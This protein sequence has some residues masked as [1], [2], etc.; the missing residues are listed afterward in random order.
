M[1][2]FNKLGITS[3]TITLYKINEVALYSSEIISTNGN[4][5]HP[6]DMETSLTFKVYKN[7][8]D[9]TNN[10]T[11]IEWRKFSFDS[12]EI[13]E[14]E[15][16][17]RDYKNLKT[18]KIN[19]NDFDKKC[20]IQA[21]AYELVGNR[22]QCVASARITLIDV[23]ELYSNNTPPENPSEGALWVDTSGDTSIIYTWN[24]EF[25]EWRVV[26]RTNPAVRNLINNSNF[27]RLN[28]TGF[29]SEKEDFLLNLKTEY[30]FEKNWLNLKTY[31]PTL[32]EDMTAGV[33]QT[34]SYPIIH[35]SDYTFSLK[36]YRKNTDEYIG[37]NLF[38]KI[39]S[40]DKDEVATEICTLLKHISNDY[41]DQISYSFKSLDDTENIKV[42]IGV[43]P[44]KM[45]DFYITELSLYNTNR[46]YPWESSPE[47]L[48]QQLETK[49]N[50]DQESVFNALTKNGEMEGIYVSVDEDGKEHY[51]FNATHIKTGSL[52]GGL[53]NGIGLN[54]KDD[55][56]G[57]SI[58]HVYK[59]ED[60]THIDMVAQNLY[61]GTEPASTKQYAES[62]AAEAESNAAGY[63]NTTVA[64]NREESERI[65][66]G[67]IATSATNV[68]T[69][70]TEY[71]DTQIS[72]AISTN[73]G[74]TNGAIGTS[75]AA[76]KT[77]ISNTEKACKKYT[78]DEIDDLVKDIND[79][80]STVNSN[81]SKAKSDAVSDSKK[82]TDEEL[83]TH[84]TSMTEYIDKKVKSV[85]DVVVKKADSSTVSG[86]DARLATVESKVVPSVLVSTVTSSI[87]YK[88]AI[89]KMM[90][91]ESFNT[92]KK[93]LDEDLSEMNKD[94]SNRVL[95]TKV[96][97]AINNSS[98]SVKI[99][100]DKLDLSAVTGTIDTPTDGIYASTLFSKGGLILTPDKEKS[101]LTI[102]TIISNMDFNVNNLDIELDISSIA[103]TNYVK[104]STGNAQIYL[105]DHEIIK[106]LLHQMNSMQ[107]RIDELEKTLD[108]LKDASLEQ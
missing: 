58:F 47:D 4:I 103:G 99:S 97:E 73:E 81:I 38:I 82:Y 45:C 6:Y 52:D 80:F 29:V 18:I 104:K 3:A 79:A 69:E 28:A 108:S 14:D 63:T 101:D 49:L 53:I 39:I 74:F 88:T 7:S 75:E 68:I 71:V 85:N 41:K 83:N 11:H 15:V 23:N 9:I 96:V 93:D 37:E 34:T 5:F 60:G 46:I 91:T 16:W 78:D 25:K 33:C 76:L 30:M 22:E 61:I 87:E 66:N 21:D 92:F 94:I 8:M 44:M 19:K 107:K 106:L 84:T 55:V 89:S 43:E 102:D 56:T 40:L 32:Y 62:K 98:E 12:S 100:K 31:K 90:D 36:A 26:G 54:I 86:I 1:P 95:N 51:Y 10:F 27:W 13:L 17:S 77:L 24:S 65:L 70:M 48:N 64:S 50:N 20:V 67:N 72:G 57:Q 42:I 35:K 2:Q 59:D 105:N